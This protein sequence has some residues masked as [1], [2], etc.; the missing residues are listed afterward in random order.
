MQ[1][2][3]TIGT[4]RLVLM[5]I[6]THAD[7]ETLTAYLGET[8]L[9][10]EANVKER[11]LRYTLAKLKASGELQCI[12]GGGRGRANLYNI[13]LPAQSDKGATDCPVSNNQLEMERGQQTAPLSD[14]RGQAAAGF[15]DEKGGNPSS[16]KGQ[17]IAERGQSAAPQPDEPKEEENTGERVREVG[18]PPEWL[19]PEVWVRWLTFRKEINHPVKVTQAEG[20][21]KKLDQF[22]A[23][24]MPPE[25][26][27][28]Q[29]IANGWQGLFEVKE[30]QN[31]N[32]AGKTRR[33]AGRPTYN[34]RT[35]DALRELYQLE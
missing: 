19:D 33:T 12:V 2:S 11:N 26:V 8:T 5:V 31:G 6:A 35:N 9:C 15:V 28:E 16:Q 3:Q 4:E 14:Q 20:Q 10:K 23:R 25:A 13:T 7:A 22:R 30:L 29:S 27:L 24:G 21:F 18:S 32:G 17:P 34:D 1:R